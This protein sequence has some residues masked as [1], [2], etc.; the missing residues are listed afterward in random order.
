MNRIPQSDLII[1]HQTHAGETGKNNE[2]R[3]AVLTYQGAA[4]ENGGITVAVVAD[5]IGGHRAGEVA[6]QI[7][8]DTFTTLFDQADS[9]S[10]LDLFSRAFSNISQTI[11]KHVA[12]NPESEGMGTTCSAA[13]IANRRLYIAF[14]G[15]SRIYLLRDGSIRQ[16]SVDHTW[17]QE[18]IE[19]GILNKQEARK[20]PNRHV[21]RRHLGAGQDATPDYRLHLDDSE[22]AE[23]ARRNQGLPLKPGDI[24][25]LSSDGMTD[26]VEDHEILAAFQ[27]KTPQAA[28]DALVLLARQRGGHDNITV[29]AIQTPPAASPTRTSKKESTGIAPALVGGTAIAAMIGIGLVVVIAAAIGAYVVFFNPTPT[30]APSATPLPSNTP[31]PLPSDTPT[32]QEAILQPDTPTLLPTATNTTRP[33]P[34]LTSTSTPT[35]ARTTLAPPTLAPSP[36]LTT[37]I[38]LTLDS[39]L[40]TDIAATLFPILD[41][42]TSPSPIP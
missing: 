19:H 25:L 10:Y 40:A 32:P 28:V 7:A 41:I 6:S 26:L 30:P 36:T 18:A 31:I 24:V 38:D 34:T 11:A 27:G 16:I 29:T 21:V 23:A 22:S 5:G 13:L 35:P 15:D 20:H 42:T 37:I 4:G 2:D 33:S 1:G 12:N 17:V 14:I 8:I 3:A 39:Q 9:R